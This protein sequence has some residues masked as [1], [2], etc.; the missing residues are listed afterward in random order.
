M[1]NP[2]PKTTY[3]GAIGEIF[4]QLQLLE[5]GIQAAPPIKDS[6]NDLIAIKGRN[7]KFIQ[8]KT[9]LD[10]KTYSRNLPEVYDLVFYVE[11]ITNDT[12]K[13]VFDM[14]VINVVDTTGTSLGILTQELTDRIWS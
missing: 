1:G 3:V 9:K 10:G 6:G 2:L 14:I 11:L 7:I 8:I 5:F 12:G 13:F 4:S